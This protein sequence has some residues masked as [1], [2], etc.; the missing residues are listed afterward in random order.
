MVKKLV[1]TA[2][3]YGTLIVQAQAGLVQSFGIG[4]RA[5]AMGEAVS[6]NSADPFA[7]YYNPAGLADID[8]QMITAGANIMHPSGEITDIQFVD[9]NG[10]DWMDNALVSAM[11]GPRDIESDSATIIN[12]GMGYARPLNDRY[13]F[14][15]A[16]YAPYGLHANWDQDYA[17]NPMALYCWR[18][19]YTR[20]VISPTL[21]AKLTDTLSF[22]FGLSLG[23]SECETG[24]SYPINP[25]DPGASIGVHKLLLK[26]DD[27]FNLSA[28]VGFLYRPSDRLSLG[29]TYRSKAEGDFKG[30]VKLNG[31]RI[32]SASMNYDHPEAVQAGVMYRVLPSLT[33]EVDATWTRWGINDRQIEI[34]TL[35]D[36]VVLAS[37]MPKVIPFNHARFWNDITRL[38]LG[39]E[40]QATDT[41]SLRAGYIWDPTPVPGHTFDLGWPDTDRAIYDVG[42]GWAISDNWILDG[43]IQYVNS[44]PVRSITGGSDELNHGF[45]RLFNTLTRGAV[46]TIDVHLNQEGTLW[47]GGLTVS[48]LF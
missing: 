26:A 28:N 45:G 11:V 44:R 3:I 16:V 47:S 34:V 12:P 1:V 19:L 48:Y 42:F 32:G 27:S 43:V 29:L 7:V 40:W 17:K 24:K 36:D 23:R 39:V 22:G 2:L 13:V 25:F 31:R 30:H 46:E 20:T 14:G 41:F 21:G 8:Q 9:Q 15:V 4:A 38:Q 35:D 37:G 10:Y 5:T 18:S 6:A 33:C